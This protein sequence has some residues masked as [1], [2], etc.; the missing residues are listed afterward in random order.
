MESTPV[1]KKI[2]IVGDAGCGKT[3]LL[4]GINNGTFPEASI[5]AGFEHYVANLT[6]NDKLYKVTLWDTSDIKCYAASR[7]ASYADID[8][9]LLCYAIDLPKSLEDAIEEWILE[10]CQYLQ[11]SS[12]ILVGCKKDLRDNAYQDMNLGIN[13]QR[14]LSTEEGQAEANKFFKNQ[15]F[16]C[17]AVTGEGI[18]E[19]FEYAAAH[20]NRLPRERIRRGCIL[21]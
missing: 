4:I 9:I 12:I 19:L 14:M 6:W 21:L 15:H 1:E 17:S 2:M 18:Q 10:I 16:E 8:V 5:P 13:T 7:R 20:T 3:S 11:L